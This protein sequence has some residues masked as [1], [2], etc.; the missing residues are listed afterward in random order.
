MEELKQKKIIINN[1][2]I[3][4]VLTWFKRQLHTSLPVT[5]TSYC[6]RPGTY[7]STG[8]PAFFVPDSVH[9][10]KE[11]Y[12]HTTTRPPWDEKVINSAILTMLRKFLFDLRPDA[13]SR[14]LHLR[15]WASIFLISGAGLF[16]HCYAFSSRTHL[17]TL[18]EQGCPQ[19][20]K[21]AN[22]F[23]EPLIP[24]PT[25]QTRNEGVRIQKLRNE[26]ARWVGD[27]TA[28][29]RLLAEGFDWLRKNYS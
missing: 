21:R 15:R 26:Q 2:R 6:P 24:A 4:V 20:E 14:R 7:M 10:G 1:K 17:W 3:F 27:S 12:Y 18:A 5:T 9:R 29:G 11:K 25:F 22:A 8:A 16:L 13:F 28:T 19:G 23:T